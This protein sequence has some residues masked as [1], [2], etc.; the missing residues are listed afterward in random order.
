MSDNTA[1]AHYAGKKTVVL[2][3]R[4]AALVLSAADGVEIA[5]AFAVGNESRMLDMF[6]TPG[7]VIVS[8]GNADA[9][10]CSVTVSPG[11]SVCATIS[12]GTET[13]CVCPSNITGT[14]VTRLPNTRPVVSSTRKAEHRWAP[15]EVLRSVVPSRR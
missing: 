5:A 6:S 10:N 3:G 2:G 13:V 15:I 11:L 7:D 1:V 14:G 8:Y 12:N 9:S 4:Y